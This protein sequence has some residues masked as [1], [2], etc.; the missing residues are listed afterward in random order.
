[1]YFFSGIGLGL[2]YSPTLITIGFYFDK[3]RGL[4]SG[5]SVGFT[6]VG[7]LSGSLITQSLIDEYSVSGAFLLIGALSLHF[8]FFG[9]FFR[10]TQFETKKMTLSVS[11]DMLEAEN[12]FR[13]SK[14]SLALHGVE[15]RPASSLLS[16]LVEEGDSASR[17]RY[18]SVGSLLR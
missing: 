14:L 7:I 11:I 8:C 16:G 4:A 13:A 15:I 18:G 17:L 5:I 1:M 12:Q 2:C 10:P 3:Y 9:M 6:A